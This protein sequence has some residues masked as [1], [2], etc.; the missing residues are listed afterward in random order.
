M[1][2]LLG[3]V[4]AEANIV[5]QWEGLRSCGM[6]LVAQASPTYEGEALVEVRRVAA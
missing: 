3:G 4:G 5:I 1:M 6:L 2:H